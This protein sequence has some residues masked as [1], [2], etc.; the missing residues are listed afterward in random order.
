VMLILF[1]IGAFWREDD[2]MRRQTVSHQVPLVRQH[3]PALSSIMLATIMSAA[4]VA[5]WPAAALSLD[6]RVSHSLPALQAPGAAEGWQPLPQPMTGWTP[7][8]INPLSRIF[9]SYAKGETSAGLY[10]GYYRNQR[11][12]AELITSTNRLVFS[13]DRAWRT[14]HE[15]NRT[16]LSTH[17]ELNLNEAQLDGVKERLLVWRSY[18]IDGQYTTNLYWGKLLQAKSK[19]LGRGDD[20]ATIIVY[21]KMDGGREAAARKLLDFVDAMLPAITRSL[22]NARSAQF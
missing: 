21:T 6:K 16:V 17:G 13:R 3:Q 10:I 12:G 22:E 5:L 8:F 9:Q 4:M 14:T 15:V 2:P 20:G 11:Q 1:W 19:L 7:A 18:W